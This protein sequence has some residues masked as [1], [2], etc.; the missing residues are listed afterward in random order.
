MENQNI[1]K[2]QKLNKDLTNP[3]EIT[4]TIKI[5]HFFYYVLSKTDTH[6]LL[7]CFLLFL[8]LLQMISN[9]CT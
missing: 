7:C 5:F 9:A 3:E 2:N 4:L 1:E 8:E 6:M